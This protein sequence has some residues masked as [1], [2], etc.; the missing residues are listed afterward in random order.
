MVCEYECIVPLLPGTRT[1]HTATHHSNYNVHCKKG[2]F[3]HIKT[4]VVMINFLN[5]PFYHHHQVS[6]FV[7]KYSNNAVGLKAK[8]EALE[9]NVTRFREEGFWFLIGQKNGEE[10]WGRWTSPQPARKFENFCFTSSIA[11]SAHPCP[12]WMHHQVHLCLWIRSP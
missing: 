6:M 1:W 4:T 9:K 2:F 11:K 8:L 3:N 5:T 12:P 10:C 7:E